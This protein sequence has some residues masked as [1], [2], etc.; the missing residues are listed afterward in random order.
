LT[1]REDLVEKAELIR[2]FKLSARKIF[3][4]ELSMKDGLSSYKFKLMIEASEGFNLQQTNR[5][6]E[7]LDYINHDFGYLLRDIFEC[8][9]VQIKGSVHIEDDS[10]KMRPHRIEKVSFLYQGFKTRV[11]LKFYVI[12]D[13]G[14][15]A[16]CLRYT[17]EQV[18]SKFCGEC[19][20]FV[21]SEFSDLYMQYF[22]I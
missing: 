15:C 10:Y 3:Q 14:E 18:D 20:G 11:N 5:A 21:N 9:E 7:C 19:A 4:D 8:S 22:E 16:R 13:K 12:R 6:Q 17:R 1:F 2:K